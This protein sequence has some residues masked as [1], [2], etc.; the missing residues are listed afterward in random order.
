MKKSLSKK[1]LAIFLAVLMLVTA[2]PFTSF[3]ADDSLSA[4]KESI[5][6]YTD[7][8]DGTVYTNMQAA[9]DAYITAKELTDAYEYGRLTDTTKLDNAKTKLDSAVLAMQPYNLRSSDQLNYTYPHWDNANATDDAVSKDQSRNVLY[10]GQFTT[11]GDL[12]ASGETVD[13]IGGPNCTD[14]GADV[15]TNRVYYGETVLLYDGKTES[16]Q[17]TLTNGNVVTKQINP[18]FPIMASANQ[19]RHLGY[20]DGAMMSK[21]SYVYAVV[22][23]DG[24]AITY[25]GAEAQV[26]NN[27]RNNKNFQVVLDRT[28][29][30][31]QRFWAGYKSNNSQYADCYNSDSSF[32]TGE[33]LRQGDHNTAANNIAGDA[34]VYFGSTL[35]FY[36]PMADTEYT[37]TDYIGWIFFEEQT[38]YY[39]LWQ[40]LS[41]KNWISWGTSAPSRL[42]TN[43]V[44]YVAIENV[45]NKIVNSAPLTNVDKYDQNRSAM[46]SYM[47]AIDS[48]TSL[49]TSIDKPETYA[50]KVADAVAKINSSM[51]S[52]SAN[53]EAGLKL[54]ADDTSYVDLRAAINQY[55]DTYN[56]GHGNDFGTYT[57]DTWMAFE[58]AFGLA[59]DHMD[60]LP[61]THYTNGAK[62]AA[63]LL[64]AGRALKKAPGCNSDAYVTARNNLKAALKGENL[65]SVALNNVAEMLNGN[66]VFWEVEDWTTVPLSKQTELDKETDLLL[67]A[68]AELA[69]VADDTSYKLATS[70]VDTLNADSIDKQVVQDYLDDAA[71]LVDVEVEILGVK[72][73]GYD[74]DGA[75][76]AIMSVVTANMYW[77]TVKCVDTEDAVYYLDNE[78]VF[79]F[80][81]AGDGSDV[82]NIAEFHYNT[83]V[84]V[85]NPNLWT[86]SEIDLGACDWMISVKAENT[87]TQSTPKYIGN[88]ETIDF[89]VRGDTTLY[90]SSAYDDVTPASNRI[91]FVNSSG[92][93]IDIGYMYDGETFDIAAQANIPK[94]A[95]HEVSGYEVID[96]VH[97]WEAVGDETVDDVEFDGNVISYIPFGCDIVIQVNYKPVPQKGVF[98]VKVVDAAYTTLL[99]AEYKYN[100]Y[101]ELTNANAKSYKKVVYNEA[102]ASYDTECYLANTSAYNFYVCEDI[103]I[104]AD[105]AK[106]P[107]EIS[108]NVMNKPV[109]TNGRTY[110][111]GSFACVPEGCEV[112]SAG[113][114]LDRDNKYPTDLSLAKVDKTNGVY[115]MSTTK[116]VKE[117]NQFVVVATGD[118][119]LTD[120]NYVAYVI[121]SDGSAVNKIAYSQIKS[122]TV[123][124]GQT[125]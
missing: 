86:Q 81:G 80:S 117:S 42:S 34:W 72:Y 73:H 119:V 24:Q 114:V 125:L 111:V 82:A 55:K 96:V 123:D 45:Y 67:E 49:A 51:V 8:M 58:R 35:E 5:K 6:A 48:L 52:I 33:T 13:K 36:R 17:V 120:I 4:L 91:K 107:A 30:V 31:D 115:N 26:P 112:I 56:N 20:S 94:L 44:N 78:G 66:L 41:P 32:I 118:A 100:D 43:V 71:A 95:F 14:S 25:G 40:G 11:S 121:Y 46:I 3:A 70:M 23:S 65:S 53:V 37:L 22:P 7:K 21:K 92:E 15:F 76:R 105:T 93:V 2:I 62:L 99:D 47:S 89:I 12:S 116:I 101:V 113:V 106:A 1:I 122:A 57:D 38:G 28:T 84:T 104:M 50:G 59:E 109:T 16:R 98:R 68:L 63:D 108:V 64:A 74:Y 79:Q 18:R 9:Y 60:A 102:E 10:A 75:A 77:Y 54:K 83:K 110:F 87:D 27:E 88:G 19:N 61:T 90:T 39:N 103:T 29:S 69:K 85:E 97:G 124:Y